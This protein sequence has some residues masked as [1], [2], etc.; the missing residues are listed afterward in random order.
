MFFTCSCALAGSG[1]KAGPLPSAEVV[2][3]RVAVNQ[4]QAEAE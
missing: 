1:Q 3:A 4:D 2:M